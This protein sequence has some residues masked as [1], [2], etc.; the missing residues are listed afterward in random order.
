MTI[1]V[2]S[3][4]LIS[5]STVLDLDP[6]P[7]SPRRRSNTLICYGN[8]D[9]LRSCRPQI[10]LTNLR[11]VPLKQFQINSNSQITEQEKLK[12]ILVCDNKSFLG[13]Q[14]TMKEVGVA[15][16]RGTAF[17]HFLERSKTI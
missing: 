1:H 17:F 8:Q 13:I 12:D 16:Q 15:Q 3:S 2:T 4:R 7:S 9:K 11:Y 14:G 5:L 6:V 10:L